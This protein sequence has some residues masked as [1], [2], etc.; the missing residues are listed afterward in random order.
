MDSLFQTDRTLLLRRLDA[1]GAIVAHAAGRVAFDGTL[2]PDEFVHL[3]VLP[4]AGRVFGPQVDQ[5][6]L[7]KGKKKEFMELQKGRV[8]WNSFLKF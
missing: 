8:A 5:R 6:F 7:P 1:A 2:F 4:H 3:L